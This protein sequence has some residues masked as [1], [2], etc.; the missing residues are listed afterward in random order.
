MIENRECQLKGNFNNPT[1]LKT[2]WK[3]GEP[4]DM[5]ALHERLL[6]YEQ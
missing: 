5:H 2:I 1:L 6:Q 3:G 4:C